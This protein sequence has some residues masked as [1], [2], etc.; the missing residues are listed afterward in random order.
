MQPKPLRRDPERPQESGAEED[1]EGV[2]AMT[3]GMEKRIMDMIKENG[4]YQTA[5]IPVSSIRFS[6]DFRA[7][8]ERNACGMYGKSWMCPPH[9]GPAERLI[10]DI[11][12]YRRT[13]V[14]QTVYPLEDSF[15]IEGMLKAGQLHNQLAKSIQS[16]VRTLT[17]E[18]ILHLGAGGCRLCGRC[19]ILDKSP[20]RFPQDALGS[21]EAYCVD[22]TQLAQASGLNYLNGANTVTYFGA[23]FIR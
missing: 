11:K 10:S 6:L 2:A 15:D 4:A 5:S 20:C 23:L 19:A 21:L 12:A 1:E 14:Y 17:E 13:I 22:V 3:S 7:M 9:I 8:C 18:T 16:Y